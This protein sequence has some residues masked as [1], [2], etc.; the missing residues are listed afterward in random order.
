MGLRPHYLL[1][2]VAGVVAVLTLAVYWFTILR[3]FESARTRLW[4][5]FA[6]VVAALIVT[7]GVMIAPVRIGSHFP[8]VFVQW[9][10]CF[11]IFV[12]GLGF[13]FDSGRRGPFRNGS[14]QTG[15]ASCSENRRDAGDFGAPVLA[16]AAFIRREELT[17][18]EVE[19]FIPGLPRG[20][21]RIAA[22][23]DQRHPP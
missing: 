8:N 20:P 4:V 5:R 11:A 3:S 6:S 9:I 16:A 12:D 14:T 17:F 7:V 2:L 13:V 18:K 15:K 1:D 22:R 19:V 10:R 21:E 23:P